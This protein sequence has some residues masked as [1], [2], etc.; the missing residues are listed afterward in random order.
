MGSSQDFDHH[1]IGGLCPF[2]RAVTAIKL[3][4][5]FRCRGLG[6]GGTLGLP[7]N[8]GPDGSKGLTQD[9]YPKLP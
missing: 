5:G 4:S 9:I 1:P 8:Y 2:S 7:A 6:K 3:Q